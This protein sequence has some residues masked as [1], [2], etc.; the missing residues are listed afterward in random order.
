[1]AIIYGLSAK[2]DATNQRRVLVR[3]TCG[4]ELN[5]R[6]KTNVFVLPEY[7][8]GDAKQGDIKVPTFRL[9]T[10]EKKQ[11]VGDLA[12]KRAQLSD[13]TRAIE[14]AY[15]AAGRSSVKA[16]PSWLKELVDKFF[17]PEKYAQEGEGGGSQQFFEVFE[18]FMQDLERREL[19]TM[20]K[21]NFRVVMNMLKRY[22]FYEQKGLGEENFYLQFDTITA[23]TMQDFAEFLKKEYDIRKENPRLFE[24][25]PHLRKQ[26]PR[27]Q[28]TIKGILTK[29]RTFFKWAAD[30]EKTTANPF[31]K[32]AV[33]ECTYGTPYYISIDERNQLY[34]TDL[35]H[36]P[37]L[38]AQRDIFVFQCLIGCRV[39]D[40]YRFTKDNVIGGAIE[41]IA[42]KTKEGSPVT[43]RVPLNAT[44]KAIL[45]KYAR[46]KGAR[47]LP[48]IAEQNYNYA[49][50]EMFTLA[51]FTRKVTV[52]DP[53]TGEDVKRP[54]NEVASSHMARRTFIGNLYKKVKDPNLV[55]ALSGH[56]EGSKA[57]A[58]YRTIDEDMRKELVQMLE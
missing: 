50:K 48:F 51:G 44:A 55:G 41:Y 57:F 27:G 45:K 18:E 31:K 29:L 40:L 25:Y 9:P 49:I 8:D 10:I 22:E 12:A 16:N 15:N 34:A 11:L 35:S 39:G 53:L 47:L 52:L 23:D 28:N 37:A 4:S 36:R 38:A 32:F 56:K 58:R 24:D 46:F 5:M 2:A 43:V 7:W 3:L 54:L 20:R 21:R 30:N 14:Q 17:F 13:L 26:N 42:R 6:A 1:M 33:G 19:S